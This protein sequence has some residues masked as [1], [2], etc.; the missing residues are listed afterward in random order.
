MR[1]ANPGKKA[2]RAEFSTLGFGGVSCV[3][4]KFG[5]KLQFFYFY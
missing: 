2:T 3:D 4:S 1:E 5:M